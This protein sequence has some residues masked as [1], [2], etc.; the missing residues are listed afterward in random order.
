MVQDIQFDKAGN[1]YAITWGHGKNL[2]SVTPEGKWRFSRMLPEM[3]TSWLHVADD[4]LLAYT[5]AG[6]R[7]YQL[8]LDNRPINQV[9]LNRDPGDALGCD[10]YELSTIDCHYLPGKRLLL[11]NLG[12]R[13]RLLDEQYNIVAE[14]RGESYRDKDVS[15]QVMYRTCHGYALS[16]DGQRLAVLEASMYYTKAGHQDREV[17]DT[18]LVI[19]DL[20]GKLLAEYKNLD[21]GNAVTAT[22]AWSAGTA[23]PVAVV[24][25][26][27]RWAFD[28][29]LK[30]LSRSSL[31]RLEFNLGDERF[32]LRDDRVLVY[33]D[34]FGH[35]QCR[36]GP[37]AVLPTYANLSPD[38]GRLALLD[39]YGL[40]SLFS[41]REGKLLARFTVP[42]LGRVLRFTP[43]GS[44]VVVGTFQGSLLV[45]DDKGVLQWRT[46]LGEQ[47]DILGQELPLFDPAFPDM[48]EKLWPVSRDRPGELEQLVRL[49]SNRLVNGDAESAG[50]W[51]GAVSFHE[52]GYES[53][54]SLKVGEQMVGQEITG[55]L[56]QHATWV[57]E[58]Y[59]R[60]LE[61]GAGGELL[62]GVMAQGDFP[63]SVARHFTASNDWRFGRVPMK[64]GSNCQK[65][66]V[67]FATR[68]GTVLVDGVQFRRL[69]FPSI[70][71]LLFEPFHAVKPV[72]LENQLYAT[73]YHPFGALKEQAPNKAYL[74]NTRNGGLPLVDA[75]FFQNGRLNDITSR[76][77]NQP[78]MHDPP[79]VLGL[80]EP[81]WIGLVALYFNAY[82]PSN[83]MPHFDIVVTDLEAKQDRVVASVRHNGQVFR[84]VKFPPVKTS[85]I[86]IQP[87]NSISRLRTITEVELY[88]P[89]S[90]KEGAPGFLDPDGQNTYMGD[91]SRVDPRPRKL[92]DGF[93]PPVVVN[94]Q[95][96]KGEDVN[97]YAPLAQILVG[98]DQLHVAR[99]YGK[100]SGY[101][102]ADLQKETYGVRV[103]GLGFTPYGTLYGGLV[104]R[105]GNDGKLYCLHP[106]TGAELWSV[107]LGD[108]LFGCPVAI[109][110]DVYLANESGK[111]FQVDLASGGILKEAPLSGGVLGSPATDGKRLYLISEDG[112]LHCRSC[113]DLSEVWKIRI[114]PFTD[115]TPA[116]A[117]GIVYLGDQKGTV[118]AVEAASG[119]V[120][121]QAELGD[122]FTRCPVVG[123]DHV[124]LG[125]RGGTLAVLGRADGKVVWSRK[126]DSRFD[127]EP[128][129]LEDQLL[130][131]RGNKAML[132]RLSDGAERPLEL[133]GSAA[134][135]AGQPSRTFTLTGDPLVSFSYYKG[136]LFFIE[137]HGEGHHNTLYVNYPWHVNGGSFTVLRPIPPPAGTEKKP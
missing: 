86:K 15:D 59:Y 111:L 71:H 3:G 1:L 55:Y 49:D 119:K 89:L 12:Q 99:A 69:R 41:A 102:M 7:M 115:S 80:K 31:P 73:R 66:S 124:I 13:M 9:R 21:N 121:W 125:C 68:K 132:A 35:E 65:L 19:R 17:Y 58:F 131:F 28:G 45:Y 24:K 2:Y 106:E 5:S 83:V 122:E 120:R 84:L 53:K 82:D 107:R 81:R 87:V 32:L 75:G 60:S 91:F 64:S 20:T 95:S 29:E 117:G 126:I 103:C 26:K 94:K 118:W 92:A 72:V 34:R 57:L 85:L 79:V 37:F 128:L 62:A 100:A 40:L 78:L 77:Y 123:P 36:L 76:W 47:N 113:S 42:E 129:V 22:V 135:R 61:P 108:R 74:E 44:R 67:G 46:T 105:C 130:Y 116:V 16:P 54:R 56:G 18:H 23:G 25:N 10:N 109:Q 63:D 50:G 134:P 101:E 127:Y 38:G 110:D 96:S 114:A 30:L 11:H 136:S 39:E 104:L 52:E 4:R 133:Q 6:A 90:G 33:W 43:D 70:N 27:E 97:W 88:G 14:W 51:Q 112:V 98:G 93:Q 48:T 137:R 8:S